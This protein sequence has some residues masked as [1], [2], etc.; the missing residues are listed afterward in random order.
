M[1]F[2]KVASSRTLP[3][4]S[5]VKSIAVGASRFKRETCKESQHITAGLH[6]ISD[7]G[8]VLNMGTL[9]KNRIYI[10]LSSREPFGYVLNAHS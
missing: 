2:R 4:Y 7:L 5:K 9:V 3:A 10:A 6:L 1:L 8:Y